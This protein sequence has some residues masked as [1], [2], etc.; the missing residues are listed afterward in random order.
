MRGE[1]QLD[2][3]R[4][5]ARHAAR[6]R[7]T[8]EHA[9]ITRQEQPHIFSVVAYD[10]VVAELVLLR[11]GIEQEAGARHN[12]TDE[13]GAQTRPIP[14]AFPKACRTGLPYLPPKCASSLLGY[15]VESGSDFG[16]VVGKNRWDR[17]LSSRTPASSRTRKR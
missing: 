4:R 6:R 1:S 2:L 8:V 5:D 11:S 15:D 14:L 7:S 16:M 10:M 17:T 3:H 13:P 12:L 9:L